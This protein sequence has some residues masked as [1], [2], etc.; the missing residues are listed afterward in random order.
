MD[1]IEEH[2][3]RLYESRL[4]PRVTFDP[5]SEFLPLPES[6][7]ATPASFGPRDDEDYTRRLDIRPGYFPVTPATRGEEVDDPMVA[8][9]GASTIKTTTTTG[10]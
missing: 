1:D 3:D 8:F 5:K 6:A 2:E 4:D 10:H 9:S 7:V